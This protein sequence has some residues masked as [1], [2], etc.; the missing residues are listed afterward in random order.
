MAFALRLSHLGELFVGEC[1]A[2]TQ[3]PEVYKRMGVMGLFYQSICML[4]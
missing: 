4:D 3:W 2:K 1:H